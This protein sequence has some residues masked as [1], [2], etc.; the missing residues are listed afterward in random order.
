VTRRRAA[1]RGGSGA[2]PGPDLSVA[3]IL[4]MG[5]RRL[6][7]LTAAVLALVAAAFV[8]DGR[9]R[10][11]PVSFAAIALGLLLGA[12]APMVRAQRLV[13]LTEQVAAV[14]AAREAY[15]ASLRAVDTAIPENMAARLGV[16][17]FLLVSVAATLT[18]IAAAAR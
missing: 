14:P 13:R 2:A 3:A 10:G 7:F 11:L 6:F 18:V 12:V 5:A 4:C 16:V 17:A 1:E 15:R 9:A 8:V